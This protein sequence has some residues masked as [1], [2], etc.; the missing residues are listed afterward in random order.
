METS[1]GPARRLVTLARRLHSSF[2]SL[3]MRAHA[4]LEAGPSRR[5]ATST[6]FVLTR[7]S[8]SHVT[9]TRTSCRTRLEVEQRLGAALAHLEDDDLLGDGRLELRLVDED[10]ID[11]GDQPA[12]LERVLDAQPDTAL[13]GLASMTSQLA[14]TPA[15]ERRHRRR[16][17]D[18][19][20]GGRGLEA[21]AVGRAVGT[22]TGASVGNVSG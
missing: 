19:R 20:C 16:F 21:G 6:T 14:A 4:D 2:R 10:A 15:W 1:H 7:R 13:R 17:E 12:V 3:L 22:A 9:S 8:C 5:R 18:R 11:P